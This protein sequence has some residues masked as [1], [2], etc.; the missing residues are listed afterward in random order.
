[1]LALRQP[2]LHEALFF[3][4]RKRGFP[5]IS[6]SSAKISAASVT[7]KIG[8]PLLKGLLRLHFVGTKGEIKS[9]AIF[10]RE[11]WDCSLMVIAIFCSNFA[12]VHQGHSR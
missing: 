5:F 6:R 3:V 12:F 11:G 2:F 1:L 9:E 7:A 4:E 10:V 8:L